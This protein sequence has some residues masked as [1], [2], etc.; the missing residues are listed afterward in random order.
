[1]ATPGK[2]AAD[3][4]AQ[5]GKVL[6]ETWRRIDESAEEG[7]LRDWLEAGL[8]KDIR[9]A[10]NSQTKS[11]R[12]VLPTQLC[13]KVARPELDCRCLQAARG[14]TGAFD[15]RTIAHQVV[16]PFDQ[17]NHDVLGGSP[18]P[19]VNNPLRVPEVSK[20]YRKQQKNK[21]DWDS[22]CRVLAE[23]QERGDPQLTSLALKQTLT[24]MYRR[25]AGAHVVY[26]AP[27]RISLEETLRIMQE[28]LS[29]SS[30]GDRLLALAS[31]LFSMVGERF[32]LFREVR[33]SNI[34]AADASTG[35]MADLECLNQ[36]GEVVVV[37]EVKDR[38]LTITQLRTKM[39]DIREKQV[40]EIFFVAHQGVA[41]AEKEEIGQQ[42]AHEFASG[43]NVY[44]TDLSTLGRTALSLLGEQGRRD[45]V[46]EVGRQL[47]AYRSDIAH[48]RSWAQL[49][50]SV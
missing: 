17:A 2:P 25:L 19:Y 8:L 39:A 3:L 27:K 42:V 16:V 30:G 31:A 45:F 13:V 14:G 12:Y 33:R 40:S 1:M 24:E 28:F 37:V 23:I 47:D 48:R 44:I 36:A 38:V 18:E 49:L 34:T 5:T 41:D 21:R 20:K 46:R 26:P 50:A 15:A 43:H 6:A 29:E 11:Y 32:G 22:L 10:V 7:P 4:V 9:A 35:L